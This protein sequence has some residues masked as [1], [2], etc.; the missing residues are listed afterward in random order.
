MS[1]SSDRLASSEEI[2]HGSG[3]GEISLTVAQACEHGE[4]HIL[5][6]HSVWPDYCTPG[7]RHVHSAPVTCCGVRG[8]THSKYGSTMY[9]KKIM[10]KSLAYNCYWHHLYMLLVITIKEQNCDVLWKQFILHVKLHNHFLYTNDQ[11]EFCL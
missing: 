10:F 6:E 1:P 9:Q 5:S 2:H 7:G 11:K 4:H 8:S 3:G